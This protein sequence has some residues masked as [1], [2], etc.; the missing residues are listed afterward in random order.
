MEFELNTIELDDNVTDIVFLSDVHFGIRNASIEW[1]ENIKCYFNDFFIPYIKTLKKRNNKVIVIIAGDYFDNRKYVDVNVMNSA[2]DIMENITKYANVYIMVGNHDI[3]KNCELDITSLRCLKNIKGVHVI[4]RITDMVIK[5]EFNIIM[6]P[7]VGD[8]KTENSI[9]TECKDKCNYIV[10]H[11]EISGMTYDNNRPIVNGVNMSVCNKSKIISGHI[12]KRQESDK[13]F[14]LGSPYHMDRSDIGNVK[15]IYSI[16]LNDDGTHLINFHKN[17]YSPIFCKVKYDDILSDMDSWK[18]IVNNNYVDVVFTQKNI[19]TFNVNKF[20]EMLYSFGA[21]RI[22]CVIE[23]DDV[24]STCDNIDVQNMK[25]EDITIDNMFNI[26]ATSMKLDDRI[27]DSLS[28]VNE[29][30]MKK[31]QEELGQK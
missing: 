12:H 4:D 20:V 21:R 28:K 27:W 26:K 19:D 11:T 25:P 16:K 18:N 1:N 6:I 5:K 24:V 29:Y 22:E 14:Y 17:T 3:Y 15:G 31:A 13:G 10:M 2:I 23:K 30:Y 8:Y 9:I 7:W